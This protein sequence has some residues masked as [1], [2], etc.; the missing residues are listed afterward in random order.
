MSSLLEGQSKRRA[1]NDPVHSLIR[2]TDL[3]NEI[4]K[5]PAMNRLHDIRSLGLAQL[6]F[7]GATASRFSH[8]IGTMYLA[9]K[10]AEQILSS[11][12]QRQY[13]DKIFPNLKE[14]DRDLSRIVQAVRLAALM[15][16]IGHGPFS[17]TSETFMMAG[18]SKDQRKLSE[19]E[20]LFPQ[21]NGETRNHAHEYFGI[22]IISKLLKEPEVSALLPDLESEDVTCM[23]SK[24]GAGSQLFST[25]A[26]LHIFRQIISSDIDADRM[27]YI[28]RD[29]WYTGAEFGKIDKERL[30]ENME[31][32]NP[33]DGSYLIGYSEKALGNIEDFLDSRY[34]MYKWVV[35]HHLMVAF[36]HLLK[37]S[38]YDMISS[39]LL[40]LKE[41]SWD[42]YYRGKTTDSTINSIIFENSVDKNMICR[43]LVDRRYAPLSLF[44][45]RSESYLEFE[46]IISVKIRQHSVAAKQHQDSLQYIESYISKLNTP[47]SDPDI[48]DG[49]PRIMIGDLPAIVLGASSPEP[50]LDS[51]TRGSGILIYDGNNAR[52]ME[53]V[54]SYFASLNN[55]WT[56]FRPY[57]FS[58]LVPGMKR[59]GYSSVVFRE[60][61][62]DIL[63]TNISDQR[64]DE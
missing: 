2:I 7:P 45:G 21:S 63:T 43:S 16:D 30:I 46:K 19:Y 37:F 39:G 48:D 13:F 28:L 40:S 20:S 35:R 27:D 14:S 22:K 8:S 50:A 18:I 41:F 42:N 10:M 36:D 6:V 64:I 47:L 44:K 34:K 25:P 4:L 17:H 3:E 55:E 23:L 57:Y 29:S 5:M 31:I 62:V 32:V 1:I 54:S 15:H 9:H 38:I 33:Q 58:Y 60:K 11:I 56:K 52:P 51:I 24:N 53:S 59:E 12:K 26:S 61:F 49:I